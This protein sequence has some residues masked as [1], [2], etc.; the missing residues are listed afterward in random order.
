[1]SSQQTHSVDIFR[2]AQNTTDAGVG[3]PSRA[4]NLGQFNSTKKRGQIYLYNPPWSKQKRGVGELQRSKLW[5]IEPTLR[6]K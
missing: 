4:I 5:G 3:L 1:M 2:C 6:L